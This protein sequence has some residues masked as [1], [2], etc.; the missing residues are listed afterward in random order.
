MYPENFHTQSQSQNVLLLDRNLKNLVIEIR[1]C[2]DS[3][4]RGAKKVVE[5]CKAGAACVRKTAK[6]AEKGVKAAKGVAKHGM[7]ALYACLGIV[8]GI[9]L[10]VA[11]YF[12]YKR[13]RSR[14]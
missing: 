6:A 12:G 7:T 4:K 3:I 5:K 13:Y 10:I 2:R 9:I 1:I 11:V 8:G 14:E